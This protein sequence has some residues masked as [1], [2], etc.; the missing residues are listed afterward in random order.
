MAGMETRGRR[1]HASFGPNGPG[2]SFVVGATIVAIAAILASLALGVP[3]APDA[4]ML[5]AP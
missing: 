4:S 5:T 1:D 2:L 3:I